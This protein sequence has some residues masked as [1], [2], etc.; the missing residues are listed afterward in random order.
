MTDA[1]DLPRQIGKYRLDGLLG[2]GAMGVVYRALDP[3][4]ERTVALKTVRRD[5]GDEP[6][7]REMI[8][9]FRKEAQAAGRDFR[10][11]LTQAARC[12]IAR[13]GKRL[14]A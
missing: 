12:R 2:K 10:I 13:I 11:Q 8:E 9:R 5:L 1:A 7:A 4:I 14:A 3:L 6:Q